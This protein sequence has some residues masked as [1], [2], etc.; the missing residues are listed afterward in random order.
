[1]PGDDNP[2][3]GRI[4]NLNPNFKGGNL[5]ERIEFYS[6]SEWKCLYQTILKRDN[7]KCQRCSE[8]QSHFNKLNV[9]HIKSFAQFVE[10][11]AEPTN[12]IVLCQNCHK[13]VH[14]RNNINKEFL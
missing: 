8:T 9:H 7:Y 13:F 10:L 11:R 4:G 2:M 6:S 5:P 1:M 3:F 14:S 12:L